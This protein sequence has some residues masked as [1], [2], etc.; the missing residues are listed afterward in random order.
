MVLAPLAG[1]AGKRVSKRANEQKS[2]AVAA[3]RDGGVEGQ[4]ESL[5]KH[6]WPCSCLLNNDS[7]SRNV[8]LCDLCCCRNRHTPLCCPYPLL[9]LSWTPIS[10][11]AYALVVPVSKTALC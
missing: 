7:P 11:P 8:W 2:G 3:R 4:N 1:W 9:N 5:R 6:S 10:G